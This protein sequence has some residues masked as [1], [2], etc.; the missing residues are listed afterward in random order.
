MTQIVTLSTNDDIQPVSVTGYGAAVIKAG[1]GCS[2]AIKADGSLWAWGRSLYGLED[3]DAIPDSYF[4]QK[5]MEEVELV[6]TSMWSAMALKTDGS[7]WAWGS[8]VC[9]QLGDG[10]TEL[11]SFPL[12]IMDEVTDIT[13]TAAYAFAIKTDGSLWAWGNNRGADKYIG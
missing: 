11:R 2:F 12:K 9:G 6:T 4:P 5:I 1:R 8:N 3:N 10:T 13:L 7:L